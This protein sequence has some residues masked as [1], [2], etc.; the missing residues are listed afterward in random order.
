MSSNL[1]LV[2]DFFRFQISE[3]NWEKF[4]NSK[5]PLW[6]NFQD[7]KKKTI[8][9][10][11]PL[12]QGKS[13]LSDLFP[14]VFNTRVAIISISFTRSFLKGRAQTRTAASAEH[15]VNRCECSYLIPASWFEYYGA[16]VTESVSDV[17]LYL[18]WCF[19][20]F[21]TLEI[22]DFLPKSIK[23]PKMVRFSESLCVSGVGR[24]WCQ[25]SNITKTCAIDRS[26]WVDFV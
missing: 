6:E 22:P 8:P 17:F 20:T 2:T 13:E 19:A 7:Q 16:N 14:E 3:P 10:K 24:T 5:N 26:R 9:N 18:E 11:F 1:R 21:I 12:L 4:E 15:I 23:F 25:G